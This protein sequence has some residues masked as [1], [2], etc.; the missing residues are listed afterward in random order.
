MNKN[1]PDANYRSYDAMKPYDGSA[2]NIT[3]PGV[4]HE[5]LSHEEVIARANGGSPAD[6]S[7]L[8]KFVSDGE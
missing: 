7:S 5:R 6:T 1:N 2:Q 8:G 4:S 3:G